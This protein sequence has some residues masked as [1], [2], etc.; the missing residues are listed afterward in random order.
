[1]RRARAV[2]AWPSGARETSPERS[3]KEDE[4]SEK[5]MSRAKREKRQA[6]REEVRKSPERSEKK[7]RAGRETRRAER[8]EKETL[9]SAA[10]KPSERRA[11]PNEG[12]TD[13]EQR[14]H[15]NECT[16]IVGRAKTRAPLTT[17][18]PR[19][20]G[21]QA[22]PAE[23]GFSET[24]IQSSFTSSRVP[25]PSS[26]NASL[27]CSFSRANPLPLAT[28]RLLFQTSHHLLLVAD[29]D[30][31]RDRHRASSQPD[32]VPGSDRR[33]VRAVLRCG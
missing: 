18:Q 21:A 25:L 27:Y 7:A 14:V 20:Y 6:E 22:S 9:P 12:T 8:E 1:M 19:E 2:S 29:A 3:E 15:D 13:N 28:L 31:A 4:Q 16:S 10:R 24:R 30:L 32:V 26:I 33:G 11:S 23:R 5:E 17:L